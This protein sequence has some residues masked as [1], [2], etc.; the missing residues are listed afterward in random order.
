MPPVMP[1]SA[2]YSQFVIL[3]LSSTRTKLISNARKQRKISRTE[4]NVKKNTLSNLEIQAT[5]TRLLMPRMLEIA[6]PSF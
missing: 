1:L 4:D 3:S 6:F 5:T 2:V